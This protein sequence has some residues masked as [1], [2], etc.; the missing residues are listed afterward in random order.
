MSDTE[1]LKHSPHNFQ[2]H[3]PRALAMDVRGTAGGAGE[4]PQAR[5]PGPD[6]ANFVVWRHRSRSNALHPSPTIV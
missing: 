5:G 1:E 3:G 4:G 2:R 6:I